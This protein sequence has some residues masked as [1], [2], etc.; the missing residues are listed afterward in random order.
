MTIA[1]LKEVLQPA[2]RGGFAVPG[3]VCLGWEDM[4]AFVMAAE[5]EGNDPFSLMRMVI[6]R[7]LASMSILPPWIR[8]SL[9]DG[10]S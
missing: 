6:E 5:A 9:P 10:R 4:R 3:L 2:L 7:P 1:T 8:A